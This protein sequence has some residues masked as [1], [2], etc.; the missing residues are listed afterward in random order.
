MSYINTETYNVDGVVDLF[1]MYFSF[2]CKTNLHNLLNIYLPTSFMDSIN[3][4]NLD[5]NV[6][7][8]NNVL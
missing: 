1:K 4:I 7:Y 6:I 2:S 5:K 8:N 3:V